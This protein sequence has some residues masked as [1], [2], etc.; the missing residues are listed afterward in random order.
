M[1]ME[2]YGSY[3]CFMTLLF[4]ARLRN[5]IIRRSLIASFAVLSLCLGQYYFIGAFYI[6]ML[7]ADCHFSN[8]HVP[9]LKWLGTIL[10]VTLLSLAIVLLSSP[11]KMSWAVQYTTPLYDFF[12]DKIDPDVFY[13]L[14]PTVG[15][16]LFFIAASWVSWL[17][18]FLECDLMQFFGR[19]SFSLYLTH[20]QFR[21]VFFSNISVSLMTKLQGHLLQYVY[22]WAVGL[23]LQL[24][25]ANWHE[26]IVDR[27]AIGLSFWLER[28]ATESR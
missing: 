28:V 25:V 3:V 14:W 17:R 16:A 20:C 4:L 8:A 21:D 26:R 13:K 22:I 24:I 2:Y 10:S 27:G 11:P 18:S 23:P 12:Y 5:D 1:P 19:V 9:H 7:S 15:A 6:G